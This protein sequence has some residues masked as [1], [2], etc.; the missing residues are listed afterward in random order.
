[1]MRTT[2]VSLQSAS[3]F[4]RHLSTSHLPHPSA[5][6]GHAAPN[7]VQLEGNVMSAE[8]PR[9][10]D[11]RLAQ[12]TE[13]EGAPRPSMSPDLNLIEHL[14]GILKWRVEELKVCNIHQ[15]YD[16]LMEE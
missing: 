4:R 2:P 14:W 11:H 13:G 15:L 5:H 1:M 10:D 8:Q 16:V 6:P 3:A 7:C 9:Q 12:D